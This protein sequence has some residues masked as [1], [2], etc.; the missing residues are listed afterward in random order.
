MSL[1][2]VRKKILESKLVSLCYRALFYFEQGRSAA[3]RLYAWIP[4]ILVIVAALKIIFEMETIPTLVVAGIFV[5]IAILFFIIGYILKKT[6]LY[7]VDKHTAASKDPIQN[8]IY[9]A[10]LKINKK[11]K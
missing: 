4:E 7:D 11:F 5:S 2:V 10:S 6:G 3:S 8:E 9:T 1:E